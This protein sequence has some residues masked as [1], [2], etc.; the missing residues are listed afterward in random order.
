MVSASAGCGLLLSTGF[1]QLLLLLAKPSGQLVRKTITH[2]QRVLE[3]YQV[4][5]VTWRYDLGK[6][7]DDID[8]EHLDNEQGRI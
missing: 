5:P 1:C 6:L 7:S 4:F 2:R 3:L 8:F